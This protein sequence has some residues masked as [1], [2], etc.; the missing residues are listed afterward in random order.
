MLIS[1][2]TIQQIKDNY[3]VSFYDNNINEVDPKLATEI[4]IGAEIVNGSRVD[5][6]GYLHNGIFKSIKTPTVQE[7]TYTW[8]MGKIN[9]DKTFKNFCTTFNKLI[10]NKG[11][12]CYPTSY[13]IGIFVAIGYRSS[14]ADTKQQIETLLDNL[15]VKYTTEYSEGGWVFRYKISRAKE[16]ISLINSLKN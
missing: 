4:Y 1:E 12:N 10:N 5:K 8:L 16:N 9:A 2:A 3:T 13:G 11:L 14:I 15:G 6:D 7:V